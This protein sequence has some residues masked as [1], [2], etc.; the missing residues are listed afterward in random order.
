[1]TIL[2]TFLCVILLAGLVLLAYPPGLSAEPLTPVSLQ[3]RW[4]H[5]FQFAGYYA[6]LH[7][8]FYREAGLEVTLKE[9]GPGADPVADVLA[10]RSDFGIGVS[11]LVI[12]Y[13]KGKPVL[14]LGPVFQ[15]SPNILI[16]HGRNQSPDNLARPGSGKPKIALMG[17]D[18][19]VE[20]KAIFLN[21]GISLDKLQ[22]VPD[23]NHLEDFLNQ[24]VDEIGRAHV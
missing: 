10:G 1:M 19:D 20:L 3:L 21:E 12:D 15:H 8:G 7:K 4:R 23:R 9:G 17:G 6:A 2:R 24:H 5:Q 13:L 14:L 22:I 11:S 16:V 18:Q